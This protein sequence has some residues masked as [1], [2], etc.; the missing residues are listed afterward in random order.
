MLTLFL[1]TPPAGSPPST[2]RLESLIL[3]VLAG[4]IT[5]ALIYAFVVLFREVLV[6]AYRRLIYRGVDISGE[7]RYSI[8]FKSGVSRAFVISLKQK[9]HAVSGFVTLTRTGEMRR[10]PTSC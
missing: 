10:N 7:W 4:V 1:Q 5:S 6:P 8:K 9:A 2:A 3:G